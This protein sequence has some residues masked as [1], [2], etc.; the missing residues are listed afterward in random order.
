MAAVEDAGVTW[1]AADEEG[2]GAAGEVVA[3]AE[4]EVVVEADVEE[5][6]LDAAGED[7]RSTRRGAEV[8]PRSKGIRPRLI[9]GG[10]KKYGGR[11]INLCVEC[12][13]DISLIKTYN[14][15]SN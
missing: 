2:E 15:M 8:S 1:M 10:Q 3:A 11:Y 13:A 6:V 14:K 7:R 12:S 4:G 5:T 9:K